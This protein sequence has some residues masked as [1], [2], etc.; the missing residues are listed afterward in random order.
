MHRT[1]II[2]SVSLLSCFLAAQAQKSISPEVLE[3]LEGSLTASPAEKAIR[4]AIGNS[5]I[6]SIAVNQENTQEKDTYFSVEVKNTGI[7]KAAADAGSS[8]EPTSCATRQ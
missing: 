8:Q 5:G 6:Q 1:R 7:S 4:N 3:S 2:A